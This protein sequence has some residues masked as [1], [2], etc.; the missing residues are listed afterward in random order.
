[1]KD[2]EATTEAGQ[3]DLTGAAS[4]AVPAGSA[5]TWSNVPKPK[6]V[7]LPDRLN[8]YQ[9]FTTMRR[10]GRNTETIENM[11]YPITID[12]TLNVGANVAN[13]C[14][15]Q[16]DVIV[17]QAIMDELNRVITTPG[18]L[19]YASISGNIREYLGYVCRLMGIYYQCA[20]LYGLQAEFPKQSGPIGSYL[21]RIG[22]KDYQVRNMQPLLSTLPMPSQ[23]KELFQK[24]YSVKR[25]PSGLPLFWISPPVAM[26]TDEDPAAIGAEKMFAE[27][28]GHM[29]TNIDDFNELL[30]IMEEAGWSTYD[31]ALHKNMIPVISDGFWWDCQ[32]T[33]IANG[34][35]DTS[36]A[37]RFVA[38]PFSGHEN[39]AHALGMF[40]GPELWDP[41]FTKL[42]AGGVW[43]THDAA[44][45]VNKST[46]YGSYFDTTDHKPSIAQMGYTQ[47]SASQATTAG[48]VYTHGFDVLNVGQLDW[49]GLGM[50]WAHSAGGNIFD[51]AMGIVSLPSAYLNEW[52]EQL[53]QTWA[54]LTLGWQ[55]GP[56]DN[57]I[58]FGD[59]I[60]PN[61]YEKT[62]AD[63]G[64]PNQAAVY[65]IYSAFVV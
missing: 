9:L 48:T 65:Q 38:H 30:R 41:Y 53:Y 60:D 55:T 26:T 50:G 39:R 33:G 64:E 59:T 15:V 12:G 57:L 8:Y 47:M 4:S 51:A 24:F 14:L 29:N 44:G 43:S 13:R 54:L 52:S 28:W 42:I 3:L 1:M 17:E 40:S 36:S 22:A 11:S 37:N 21:A 23:L 56:A 27:Q 6:S 45:Y 19:S 58:R 34:M 32:V 10:E 16:S 7:Y 5:L 31:F 2:E 20:A 46:S 63:I 61:I 18:N 49:V 35:T 25:S 62:A